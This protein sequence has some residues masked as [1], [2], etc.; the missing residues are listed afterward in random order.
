MIGM[1]AFTGCVNLETITL[2]THLEII[3]EWAFSG[4]RHLTS[5]I[6]PQSVIEIGSMA[7]NG[8]IHLKTI[9]ILNPDIK[10]AGDAFYNVKMGKEYGYDEIKVFVKSRAELPEK[11]KDLFEGSNFT[12]DK[13][14]P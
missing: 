10:I 14:S 12:L 4:C 6:I 11:L 2:P 9:T 13:I 1:N 8:C 5:I 7:F 3:G